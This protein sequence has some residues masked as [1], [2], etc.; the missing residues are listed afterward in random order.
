MIFS[1]LGEIRLFAGTYE[2]R[3]WAFCDGRLLD[4]S[5]NSTL[6]Q[7]LGFAYGTNASGTQ[8]GLPNLPATAGV[9]YMISISGEFPRSLDGFLGSIKLFAGLFPPNGWL[10]CD[11]QV[12]TVNP[13]DVNMTR[14]ALVLGSTYGGDGATTVGLPQVAP[15]PSAISVAGKSLPQYIVC[16]KGALALQQGNNVD[17]GRVEEFIGE[18]G[19]F[20]GS[21]VPADLL[22]ANGQ[23]LTFNDAAALSAVLGN[24][25]K[26]NFQ[27][28]NLA[29]LPA[30]NRLMPY[31]VATRGVFPSR[32]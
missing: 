5:G 25:G 24:N 29:P 9:R 8:F 18:V 23:S 11:G 7:L 12:L 1:V 31:L 16:V 26:A 17:S 19:A 15:F 6:W 3:G 30:V 13:Q 21:Y 10:P 2:P 20:A 22:E 14:L 4:I 32:A 27:L 28:P